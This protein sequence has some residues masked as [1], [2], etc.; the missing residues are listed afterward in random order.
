MY[1]ALIEALKP[2]SE[3]Q[4]ARHIS[5]ANRDAEFWS[6]W[7]R[8]MDYGGL[9]TSPSPVLSRNRH[10]ALEKTFRINTKLLCVIGTLQDIFSWS[11]RLHI[12]LSGLPDGA[13]SLFVTGRFR[14]E[15][16]GSQRAF[17]A[18]RRDAMQAFPTV[19]RGVRVSR[20]A[21]RRCPKVMTCKRCRF[22]FVFT[23]LA[24]LSPHNRLVELACINIEVGR[25]KERL[26]HIGLFKLEAGYFQL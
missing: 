19:E 1:W 24:Q 17:S 3:A 11:G 8:V 16:L 15:I 7:S 12:S 2:L 18:F 6:E 21:R 13:R 25:D 23:A 4:F 26:W 10:R 20:Q 14:S 22:R 9:S 5:R